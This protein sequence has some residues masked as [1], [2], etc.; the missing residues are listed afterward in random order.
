ML[1]IIRA[2]DPPCPAVSTASGDV[3]RFGGCELIYIYLFAN[4]LVAGEVREQQMAIT[5]CQCTILLVLLYVR[6]Y[7]DQLITVLYGPTVTV[8]GM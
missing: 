3:G 5:R 6:A 2:L 8:R 1:G 7:V 4:F